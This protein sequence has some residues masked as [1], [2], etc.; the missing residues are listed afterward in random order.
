MVPKYTRTDLR[1]AKY[2][3]RA[4]VAVLWLKRK[5]LLRIII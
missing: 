3:K 4:F 1:E 2:A 5:I